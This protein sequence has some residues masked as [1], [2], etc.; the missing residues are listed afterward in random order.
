MFIWRL[1]RENPE[2]IDLTLDTMVMDNDEAQ[3]RYGV[4][5]TYKK[6]KGF[7]PLQAIWNGKIVDAVFRGGKKHSNYGNTVVN[8][9]RDLVRVIREEYSETV[10]II[11]RLDSGFFDEKILQA[12][13]NLGVGFICTGKMYKGV[14]EYVGVQLEDQWDVYSNRNQEW[15]YLEFGYRCD[16]WERFYRAIYTRLSHDGE[17]RLLDFARPDNVIL[18][19]IGVNP[20]VLA[21]CSTQ[22]EERRLLHTETIIE[23]HHMRGADELPHRG[24]KDF[25]FEELPFK[26]FV[27]NSVVY[28]CMLISFFLFEAFKEDVLEGVL[29]IGSYA[30]T[31]RR[32]AL[33]FAAKIIGTGRQLILK[34]T[35]AVMDNLQFDILWQRSQKPVP[36]II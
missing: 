18:T 15:K 6:V 7:Q 12:C 33:D 14:K 11:V 26:R 4:Q 30:T 29:P 34:V 10:T 24:L 8:M 2:A 28:Y 5:P 23:S 27:P 9:M 13:D 19:N 1:R 25:G 20:K 3:K 36:I 31:V 17:Q 16:S 35:R 22:E 32:K 21:N